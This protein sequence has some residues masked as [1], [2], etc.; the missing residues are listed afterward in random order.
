[1]YTITNN[2]EK[3]Y[4]NNNTLYT[5]YKGKYVKCKY[6]RPSADLKGFY[7]IIIFIKRPITVF[8]QVLQRTS[9][10]VID[11]DKLYIKQE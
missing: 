11:T 4:I 10:Y 2:P 3:E 6:L 8:T 5:K 1:M 9:P 7:D